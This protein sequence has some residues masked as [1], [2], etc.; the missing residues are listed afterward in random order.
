LTG[1]VTFYKSDIAIENSRFEGNRGEDALNIIASSFELHGLTITDTASDAFDAD[2][3]HGTVIDGMFRRIGSA[4]GG[5]AIDVSGST[6]EISDT[7]FV[8]VSDKALSI[9]EKSV[10]HAAR[11]LIRRAGTAAASKDGSQLTLTDVEIRKALNAGL[12]AYIKKPEYGAA[13]IEAN[14]ITFV[15]TEQP[16]RVQKGSRIVIDGQLVDTEDL[17]VEQLYETVMRPGLRR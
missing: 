2:F 5:D 4:G 16:A 3:S 1:G 9:G 12:M 7:Q 15:D 6:V 17:D 14:N 8:D 11:I 10:V 13:S